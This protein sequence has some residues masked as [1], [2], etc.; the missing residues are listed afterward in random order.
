MADELLRERAF[1]ESR[2]RVTEVLFGGL[3]LF[4]LAYLAWVLVFVVISFI[5]CLPHD[6]DSLSSCRR[7]TDSH[8][9]VHKLVDLTTFVSL[10]LFFFAWPGMYI[11]MAQTRYLES[12]FAPVG[13]VESKEV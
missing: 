11:F 10:L 1:A 6:G 8:F 3:Q 12:K 9:L 2:A 7:G 4:S 13:I 5:H